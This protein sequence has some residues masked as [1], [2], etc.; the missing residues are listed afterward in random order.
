VPWG[1]ATAE[2]RHTARPARARTVRECEDASIIWRHQSR[3]GPLAGTAASLSCRARPDT[4]HPGCPVRH[5]ALAPAK[6]PDGCEELRSSRIS[7][8]RVGATQGAV[9][10][11]FSVQRPPQIYSPPLSA[12]AAMTGSGAPTTIQD[13]SQALPPPPRSRSARSHA[14]ARG[15]ALPGRISPEPGNRGPSVNSAERTDR[16]IMFHVKHLR[17]AHRTGRRTR[18]TSHVDHPSRRTRCKAGAHWRRARSPE[19]N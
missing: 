3:P 10:E 6:R 15:M 16:R 5:T 13:R 8:P 11:S 19:K 1:T 12:G 7:L 2:P 18:A 4:S 9:L 14:S 17:A